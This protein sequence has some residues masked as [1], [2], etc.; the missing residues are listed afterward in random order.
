M[1]TFSPMWCFVFVFYLYCIAW[2]TTIGH[3]RL[4]SMKIWRDDIWLFV[5]RLYQSWEWFIP[6]AFCLLNYT[7]IYNKTWKISWQIFGKSLL[8]L[9]TLKLGVY[10]FPNWHNYKTIWLIMMFLLAKLCTLN[11]HCTYFS[12]F[13]SHQEI[14]PTSLHFSYLPESLRHSCNRYAVIICNGGSHKTDIKNIGL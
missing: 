2:L 6:G 8:S 1:H 11:V 4:A 5:R 3:F 13:H 9:L 7:E 12:H 14:R 10:F